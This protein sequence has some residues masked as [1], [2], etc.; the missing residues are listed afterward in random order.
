MIDWLLGNV[1]GFRDRKAAKRYASMLLLKG[2]IKHV[3]N[4]S[5][6]NEKCYY[7]FEGSTNAPETAN[8]SLIS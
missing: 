1:R 7:I 6:F 2:Y 5:N 8:S 4:M 3:V